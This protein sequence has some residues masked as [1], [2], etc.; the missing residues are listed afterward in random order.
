[1]DAGWTVFPS[2]IL[3]RQRALGLDAF[4]VNILLQLA[5]YWWYSDNPPHPA[6]GTIAECMNV[7]PSTVRRRI[8]KMEAT[9]FI[10]REA[11]YDRK[12]GRQETNLYHFE[13]LIKQASP[14]AQEAIEAREQ[15]R[16]EDAARRSRKKPKVLLMSGASTKST[17]GAQK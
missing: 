2:V 3:E 14:F 7:D 15:R 10:R 4:D 9:S 6:K 8:A 5:R 1:M 12:S 16:I 11:R 13:G 17:R